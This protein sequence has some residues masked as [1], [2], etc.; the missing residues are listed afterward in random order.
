MNKNMEN[1]ESKD[2]I[3]RYFGDKDNIINGY[4]NIQ[5]GA[6]YYFNGVPYNSDDINSIIYGFKKRFENNGERLYSAENENNKAPYLKLKNNILKSIENNKNSL[7]SI[8]NVNEFLNDMRKLVNGDELI[9]SRNDQKYKEIIKL[10]DIFK[11]FINNEVI[12]EFNKIYK[13][14]E[15]EYESKKNK[16]KND[17]ENGYMIPFGEMNKLFKRLKDLINVN[18]KDLSDIKTKF[19]NIKKNIDSVKLIYGSV[20][21][22]MDEYKKKI[23]EINKYN[24]ISNNTEE[25]N[26]VIEKIDSSYKIIKEIEDGIRNNEKKILSDIKKLT[27]DFTNL[28]NSKAKELRENEELIKK[29]QNTFKKASFNL[30]LIIGIV[31]VLIVVMIILFAA[32]KSTSGKLIGGFVTLG[33]VII[34]VIGAFMYYKK[35]KTY[36][37]NLTPNDLKNSIIPKK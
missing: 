31:I 16:I 10:E 30:K 32:I 36:K 19:N 18:W 27:V 35:Y 33:F 15:S 6:T 8:I 26:K 21:F 34:S 23:N 20:E 9:Y 13:N 28:Y 12:N 1:T 3:Q 7:V 22:V 2:Y 29:N 24:I 17:Y 11:L 14:L 37:S 25:Y 5:A 4:Y